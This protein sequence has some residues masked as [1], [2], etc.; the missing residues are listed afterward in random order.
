MASTWPHFCLR[1]PLLSPCCTIQEH[2]ALGGPP[3]GVRQGAPPPGA[4]S[5]MHKELTGDNENQSD[6]PCF[7]KHN[8]NARLTQFSSRAL[9]KQRFTQ[10]PF[11]YE[12]QKVGHHLTVTTSISLTECNLFKISFNKRVLWVKGM[13]KSWFP[14]CSRTFKW[15]QVSQIG[16]NMLA[17][18]LGFLQATSYFS[19]H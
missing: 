17:P 15:I 14:A 7:P 18:G 11:S 19:I 6:R 5:H 9:L 10:R 1:G 3:C 13:W 4:E 16:E 2:S 12:A 8:Q